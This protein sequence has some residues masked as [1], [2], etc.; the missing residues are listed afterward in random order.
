M[1]IDIKMKLTK[2]QSNLIHTYKLL[3]Y[4][5]FDPISLMETPETVAHIIISPPGKLLLA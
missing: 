1:Y 4:F 3:P 5:V 2:W